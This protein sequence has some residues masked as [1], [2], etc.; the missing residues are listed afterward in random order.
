MLVQWAA[1]VGTLCR[2]SIP[3]SIPAC[4]CSSMRAARSD[5]GS[6]IPPEVQ[7]RLVVGVLHEVDEHLLELISVASEA[8][9]GEVFLLIQDDVGLAQEEQKQRVPSATAL[10]KDGLPTC[11]RNPTSVALLD[12]GL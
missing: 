3:S 5:T 10:K 9:V 4:R 1:R 8:R 7:K 2:D 12:G 6:G 11:G